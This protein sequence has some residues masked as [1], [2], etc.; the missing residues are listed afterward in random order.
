MAIYTR[1]GDKGKTFLSNG[2]SVSKSNLRVEAYGTVDELNSLIG[3]VLSIKYLVLSIKKELIEVQ[4]DLLEIG[5]NL[6]NPS[7]KKIS[8]LRKRVEEFEIFIDRM[9]EKLPK[10]N[11]FILPGG[12][13]A[14]AALHLGR[15]VCRHLERKIVELNRKQSVDANIMVYF[16]RLSDLLF[17]MARFANFKER[18]KE[19]IWKKRAEDGK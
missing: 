10:L 4:S 13:E 5:S 8:Y 18:K 19:I 7:A 17:T 16:N 12:G 1:A 15:A 11:N 9:T 3:T 6:A 2:K 14:G